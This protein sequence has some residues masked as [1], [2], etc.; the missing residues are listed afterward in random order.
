MTDREEGAMG[1]FVK[2]DSQLV[3]EVTH[4]SKDAQRAVLESLGH[5]EHCQLA[6]G[7]ERDEVVYQTD[8]A[9]SYANKLTEIIPFLNGAATELRSPAL[10]HLANEAVQLLAEYG[11]DDLTEIEAS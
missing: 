7:R 5:G 11:D 10:E 9:D 6:F 1:D 4:A 3:K 2:E 8:R